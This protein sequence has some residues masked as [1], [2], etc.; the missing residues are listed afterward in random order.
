MRAPIF[1]VDL[2][3]TI[4]LLSCATSTSATPDSFWERLRKGFGRDAVS[5]SSSGDE[6]TAYPYGYPNSG[7]ATVTATE[8]ETF[9]TTG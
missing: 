3:S 7:S 1:L 2:V 5:E 6:P 8:H 4:A 9:S